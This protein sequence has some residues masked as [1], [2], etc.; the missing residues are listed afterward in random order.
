MKTM[1]AYWISGTLSLKR[2]ETPWGNAG[3][4]L[5]VDKAVPY[6]EPGKTPPVK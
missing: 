4:R 2:A 5:T 1:D 3:Y 6:T